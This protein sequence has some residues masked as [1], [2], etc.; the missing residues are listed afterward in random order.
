MNHQ[1]D[2]MLPK[3]WSS[4]LF[5][6]NFQ[7]FSYYDIEIFSEFESDLEAQG[8]CRTPI[9]QDLTESPTLTTL[10][11][12]KFGAMPTV[13]SRFTFEILGPPDPEPEHWD[14]DNNLHEEWIKYADE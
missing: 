7:G 4:A 11:A 12:T 8:Y 14:E 2:L 1:I 10:D 13:C 6:G 5:Y 9:D 3:F